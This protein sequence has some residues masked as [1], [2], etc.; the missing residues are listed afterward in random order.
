MLT[1]A[2]KKP[3]ITYRELQAVIRKALLL[4]LYLQL[5]C[6]MVHINDDALKLLLRT[7]KNSV[8]QQQPVL[9]ILETEEGHGLDTE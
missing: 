8:D 9:I 6:F 2:E 1:I 3:E 5:K 4:L 7:D